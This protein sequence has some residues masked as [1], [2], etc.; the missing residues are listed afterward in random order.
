[1]LPQP[2][3]GSMAQGTPKLGLR[4]LK[5]RKKMLLSE[6]ELII[7]CFQGHAPIHPICL[8]SGHFGSPQLPL[9]LPLRALCSFLPLSFYHGA[10]VDLYRT[11][12]TYLFFFSRLKSPHR[13][14]LLLVGLNTNLFHVCTAQSSLQEKE[15]VSLGGARSRAGQG[16]ALDLQAAAGS[17]N[18]R[19]CPC[20]LPVRRV[21]ATA[22]QPSPHGTDPNNMRQSYICT[23]IPTVHGEA[24][25]QQLRQTRRQFP[26]RG[27][28]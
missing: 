18:S 2:T 16:Q 17:R 13:L 24:R 14:Y 19:H 11:T 4:E 8:F 20:Y 7:I 12:S 23:T 15:T 22:Q 5:E 9:Q 1:M 28:R 10:L 27:E 6:T 3:M 21:T 26:S 25:V